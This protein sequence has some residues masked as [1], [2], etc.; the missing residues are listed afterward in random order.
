MSGALINDRSSA[1]PVACTSA[2]AGRQWQDS[3]TG[4]LFIC[5]TSNGRNKWLSVSEM[6]LFGEDTGSCNAGQDVNSNA[7]CNV[8][9]G[10]SLGPDTGTDLGLYL[11]YDITITGYGFSADND[12]CT[13]GSFDVEV[14]DSAGAADDNTYALGATVAAGLSGEAHNS[15]TLNIDLAGNQYIIW[16]LDN[17]C[18]QNID[19][20][21]VILYYRYRHN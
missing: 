5:D 17:N 21:N 14:W 16:G 1:I 4:L 19:D 13:T 10:G 12:A 2:N 8:N 18:G 7:A 11:P 3:D 20:Y 6:A 15:S 9:W